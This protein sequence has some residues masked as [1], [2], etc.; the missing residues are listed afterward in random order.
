MPISITLPISPKC[1]L[2]FFSGS[3]SL[4]AEFI[5]KF[6]DATSKNKRIYIGTELQMMRADKVQNAVHE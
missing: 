5:A 3:H 6:S 4:V 2:V 1:V